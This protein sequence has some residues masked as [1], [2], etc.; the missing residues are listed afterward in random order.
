MDGFIGPAWAVDALCQQ[1]D[2]EMFHVEK[3]GTTLPAK[4]ICGRCDVRAECLAYAM[5][6]EDD[7][8]GRFGVFGGLG[9]RERKALAE[10][11]WRAGDPIPAIATRESALVHTGSGRCPVCNT[12]YN[13]I[14][15]HVANKH[16][17]FQAGAA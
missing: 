2:P 7:V 17:E 15:R 14:D 12:R 11:G 8:A 9:P 4:T 5:D 16:P 3:G 1:V 10:T 13:R 6:V